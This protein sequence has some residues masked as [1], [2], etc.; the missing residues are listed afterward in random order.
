[1]LVRPNSLLVG[2]VDPAVWMAFLLRC[3]NAVKKEVGLSLT[4]QGRASQIHW[5]RPSHVAFAFSQTKV[6][7]LESQSQN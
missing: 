1:M 6:G 7:G 4:E 5:E 3:E 2:D